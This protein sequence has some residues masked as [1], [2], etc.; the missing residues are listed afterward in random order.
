MLVHPDQ[1]AGL[2]S[3]GLQRQKAVPPRSISKIDWFDAKIVTTV[4]AWAP[5]GGPND[6]DVFIEFG[7]TAEELMHRFAMV[8]ANLRSERRSLSNAD[9][10][11]LC[12]AIN[13]LSELRELPGAR[14]GAAGRPDT[15]AAASTSTASPRWAC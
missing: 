12:R 15:K 6:E 8:V 11:L 13:H 14:S 2:R 5:Y 3:A 7:L 9:H 4:L 10:V 1:G